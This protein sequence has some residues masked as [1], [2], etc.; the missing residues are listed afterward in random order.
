[1]IDPAAGRDFFTA[2]RH[3]GSSSGF[4]F[5]IHG[6]TSHFRGQKGIMTKSNMQ[7]SQVSVVRGDDMSFCIKKAVD[8]LGGIQQVIRPGDHVL[9]KPNFGVNVPWDTGIITDPR[10]IDNLI[11]ICHEANPGKVVV[12]ESAVVGLDTSVVFRGIGLEERFERLGA[13]LINLD[14]DR[15]VE[16]PVPG[17]VVLKKL[18]IFKTAYES[19]VLISVPTMKTHILTGVTLG[20]KNMK[21]TL[22][23]KMKKLMH[24]IGVKE[25][26]YEHELDHAIADLNSVKRPSMTL[27]DGFVAN[28][29]YTPG[30]PGIGGTPLKFDTVLAGFDPVAVDAVSAYVMG[31]ERGEVR[32]ISYAEDRGI[33]IGDLERIEIVGSMVQEVRRPFRR[34][35]LEGLLLDFKDVSIV[36]GQGCS[37]CREATVVGLSGMSEAELE[38][39]GS[40]V[41]VM[42]SD[43]ELTERDRQKRLFLVGNCTL[44]SDLEGYRIE[45][46]PP[47]GVHVKHCLLGEY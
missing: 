29:G 43:V 26:V 25:K 24:R 9:I 8:L 3:R 30:T 34:P 12:G 5:K 40:A 41:V 27:V 7:K 31:F 15:I 35:S 20:L 17:G 11:A 16:V 37:G 4:G 22:P 14:E 46:C 18:K 44:K 36:A 10:V 38:R 45:G 19:D 23:D 13:K 21:G 1:M 32:H 28:E 42:G 2:I 6:K 47:P 33:G 39:I